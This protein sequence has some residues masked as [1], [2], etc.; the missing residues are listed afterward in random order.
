VYKRQ[1]NECISNIIRKNI[2]KIEG[3]DPQVF[4]VWHL[5]H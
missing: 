5:S 3:I 1:V 2:V 4:N